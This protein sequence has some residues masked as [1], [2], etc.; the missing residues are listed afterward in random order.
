M[1]NAFWAPMAI[2]KERP[3]KKPGTSAITHKK[4]LRNCVFISAYPQIKF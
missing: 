2:I 4:Y 1:T 3:V